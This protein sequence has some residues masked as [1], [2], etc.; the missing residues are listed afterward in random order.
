MQ[1]QEGQRQEAPAR[2][3]GAKHT[4]RAPLTGPDLGRPRAL[5]LPTSLEWS[6]P[7]ISLKTEGA[8]AG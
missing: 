4:Q 2:G 3:T 7:G 6:Q 1:R 8:G 5:V